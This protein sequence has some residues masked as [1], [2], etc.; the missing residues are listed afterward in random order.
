[1]GAITVRYL[2]TG[3]E[4]LS[5]D[6]HQQAPGEQDETGDGDAGEAFPQDNQAE[7]RGSRRLGEGARGGRRDRRGPQPA[8]VQYVTER[9]RERA[10]VD[11]DRG[12]VPGRTPERPAYAGRRE[13]D[14]DD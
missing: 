11:R 4:A 14:T 9:R 7:H 10:E 6:A 12:S 5:A 3:P 8:R 13:S 2:R 1:M